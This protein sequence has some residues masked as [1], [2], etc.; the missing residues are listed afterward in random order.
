M[1]RPGSETREHLLQGAQPPRQQ[2]LDLFDRVLASLQP[3]ACRG[4]AFLMTLSEFPDKDLPAHRRAVAAKAWIRA[5]MHGLVRHLAEVE[6]VEEPE[7]LADQLTLV[8][9]GMNAWVQALGVDGPITRAR[10]TAEVLLDAATGRSARRQH[11][12]G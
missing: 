12:T 2:I 7:A 3:D 10:A 9:E 6:T 5:R 11:T 1:R 8:L 4:C